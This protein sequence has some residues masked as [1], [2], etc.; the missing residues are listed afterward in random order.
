MWKVRSIVMM[1]FAIAGCPSA[2]VA[3]PDVH[4][5][6]VGAPLSREQVGAA[7]LAGASDAGW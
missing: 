5:Q 4:Q 6:P 3:I 1:M 7:I 2:F